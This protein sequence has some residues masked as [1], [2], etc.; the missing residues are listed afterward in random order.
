LPLLCPC[1]A[2]A[3][4]LLCPR[5]LEEHLVLFPNPSTSDFLFMARI[6]YRTSSFDG[7]FLEK[8]IAC[9]STFCALLHITDRSEWS[10]PHHSK[11][12]TVIRSP[13]IDKKSREQF[14][15]N[16]WKRVLAVNVHDVT[17]ATLLLQLVATSR[18]PGVEVHCVVT[19]STELEP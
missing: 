16:T 9:L 8:T 2:L 3:L 13:H 14:Q 6:G 5:V 10:L 12:L 7:V 17:S 15:I 1:F 4:P 11:K 18:F 19:S